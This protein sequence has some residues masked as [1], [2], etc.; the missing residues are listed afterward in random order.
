MAKA[1][2]AI[3][4]PLMARLQKASTL[5]HTD[6]MSDSEIFNTRIEVP[7]AIPAL[8]IAYSARIDGGLGSGLTVWAGPSKHF[9]TMFCLISAAAYMKAYPD[10]V[11]IFYDCEFGSP[12]DYFVSVGIDPKRV[13]HSP[14]T[15]LEDL[16]TDMVNQLN[17]ITRGDKV[18]FVV[19]SLGMAASNKEVKDAEDGNEK[20]DMTRAKINKSL[21]RIILPHLRLKDIPCLVVQHTYD[22]MEMYSK[23]VVSGGTGT[24]LAADNI[25]IIGR[26][27]DKDGKEILGYDFIINVEKSRFVKEKSRIPIKVRKEGGVF[28]WTGMFDIAVEGEYI[29]KVNNSTYALVDRQTGELDE[30]NG[31]KRADVEYDTKFW[32]KLLKTT[33][34][35]EFIHKKYAVSNG[36]LIQD[37]PTETVTDEDL[38]NLEFPSSETEE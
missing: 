37:E 26:Q 33:D 20:A 16:R 27:Q 28:K 17:E 13:L 29:D 32:I 12:A 19:D 3:K 8:N 5:E 10:S 18:V 9:K 36:E 15:T 35:K 23:K 11:C 38:E 24:Y 4:S 7:T 6:I 30:D 25:Y 31:F 2:K 21:F 1:A 22:T 34:F 14:F